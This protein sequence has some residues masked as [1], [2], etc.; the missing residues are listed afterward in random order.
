MSDQSQDYQV[1]SDVPVEQVTPNDVS[2]AFEERRIEAENEKTLDGNNLQEPETQEEE[3]AETDQFSS[4]FAALSRKE[5]SLRDKEK[6]FEQRMQEFEEKM[7]QF[8]APAQPEIPAEPEHVPADI[9]RNPIKALEEAGYTYE[10]L[11]NMILS[12]GKLTPERQMELLKEELQND[13]K[14]KYEEINNKLIEKEEKEVQRNYDE[15]LNN[16]KSEINEFVN[17]SEDFDYIQANEAQDLVFDVI[18]EYY[19]E[20]NEILDI[21]TAAMQVEQYLEEESMKLFEKSKKLKSK[22]SSNTQKPAPAPSRQ[23]PTLSNSHAATSKAPQQQRM[24]SREESIA[25][26]AKQLKWEE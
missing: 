23:S 10:D 12:D 17:S 6:Q 14:A 19:Q 11:T 5:K 15:T 13:Y 2:N 20:N 3:S 26:L 25:E 21:Q 1:S 16:F 4:K 9:R 7:A 8:Q 24:L 22:F 18:D